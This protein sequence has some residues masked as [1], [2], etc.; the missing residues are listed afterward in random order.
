MLV[1]IV[2]DLHVDYW[3]NTRFEYD[4]ES[5]KKADI[6]II[7]GDIADDIGLVIKE[8]HRA[9]DV[10]DKVLYVD[11][12]HESTQHYND[13]SI[14]N[15]MILDGLKNRQNFIHLYYNDFILDNLVIIGACGWWDFRVGD[16]YQES[17]DSFNS[18]WN[19]R[20]D[21]D[22][23]TIISNI[24]KEANENYIK[25]KEKVNQYKDKFDI[26]IVT[27]TVPCKE[28]LSEHYPCE[29]RSLGCYG[30]SVFQEFTA[31]K[32]VKYFIFGHNHDAKQETH[33]NDQTFINNARGRPS[34]FNRE[35]YV[36]LTIHLRHPYKEN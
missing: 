4:W 23:N 36:P 15:T 35:H 32:S 34:D 10:Y 5:N 19:P 18:D 6:V 30:N 13:L 20:S 2:S 1:D 17:I 11:G 16:S 3:N 27:H 22:K 29:K 26:C 7:A 21:L 8:L 24:I 25:I 9:C 12:N 14:A 31:E 28:M 33:L